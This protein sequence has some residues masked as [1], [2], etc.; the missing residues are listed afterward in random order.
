ML[1]ELCFK[2]T[3]R[4]TIGLELRTKIC[5]QKAPCSLRDTGNAMES[6]D[7]SSDVCSSDL[8]T[9]PDVGLE[10]TDLETMT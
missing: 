1:E 6:R 9:E 8:S 4:V 3:K 7:W 5:L 10:P 2:E